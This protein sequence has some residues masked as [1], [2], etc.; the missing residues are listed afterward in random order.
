M[1]SKT[2]FIGAYVEP[3]LKEKLFALAIKNRRSMAKELSWI[4]AD[5]IKNNE[6]K[7]VRGSK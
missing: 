4:I 3:A 6:Q 5:W 7:R 1:S 2:V